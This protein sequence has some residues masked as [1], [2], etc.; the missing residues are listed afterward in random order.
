MAYRTHIQNIGWA[1]WHYD[2]E[3]SGTSGLGYRLEAIEIQLVGA[4]ADRFDV[5][6]RVH[7]QNFGWMGWAKNGEMAGTSGYGYRL[8]AIQIEVVPK[9]TYFSVDAAEQPASLVQP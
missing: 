8:E 3:I 5:Y 7:C 4:D 2:K 6:Y 1:P 9:G